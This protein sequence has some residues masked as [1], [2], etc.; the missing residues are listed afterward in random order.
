[1]TEVPVNYSVDKGIKVPVKRALPLAS[2]NI[3]ESIEFPFE[4]RST[5]ATQASTIKRRTGKVFTVR[6]IDDNKCRV[7]RTK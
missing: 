7:W 4:R 3:G 2:L 1:M 6:K 5:V